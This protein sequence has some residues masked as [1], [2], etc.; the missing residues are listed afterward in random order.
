[1]IKDHHVPLN[2]QQ[3]NIESSDEQEPLIETQN[4][5]PLTPNNL[6]CFENNVWVNLIDFIS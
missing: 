5:R 4:E 3:L 2:E 1:L 6:P